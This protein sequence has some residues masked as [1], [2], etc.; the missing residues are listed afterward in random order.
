VHAIWRACTPRSRNSSRLKRISPF[1][2]A[3]TTRPGVRRETDDERKQR[4]TVQRLKADR[5][6]SPVRQCL[7]THGPFV[8]MPIT[9][10]VPEPALLGAARDVLPRFSQLTTLHGRSTLVTREPVSGG[11]NFS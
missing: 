1:P 5:G 9:S 8:T 10:S 6:S 3:L 7:T 11:A 4:L 2:K